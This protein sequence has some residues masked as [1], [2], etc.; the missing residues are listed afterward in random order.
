[1]DRSITSEQLKEAQK[2]I[3]T[4]FLEQNNNVTMKPI[5]MIDTEIII[6][7]KQR[8]RLFSFLTFYGREE[9]PPIE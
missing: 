3:F 8:F 4:W 9:L 2:V 1:M 6:N 7:D 5:T